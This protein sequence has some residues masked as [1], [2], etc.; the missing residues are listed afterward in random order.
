M[1]YT[2]KRFFKVSMPTPLCSIVG[3]FLLIEKVSFFDVDAVC[4][5]VHIL[6]F[7]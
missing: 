1:A 4:N 5:L 2:V 7:R 6:R 3:I